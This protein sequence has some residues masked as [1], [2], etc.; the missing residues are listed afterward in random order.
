MS[1]SGA[2]RSPKRMGLLAVGGSHDMTKRRWFRKPVEI[3]RGAER[4]CVAVANGNSLSLVSKGE[5][6]FFCACND[7][8]SS[9]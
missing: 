7:E 9:D 8:P 5:P 1:R 6:F 4:S 2:A 3:R